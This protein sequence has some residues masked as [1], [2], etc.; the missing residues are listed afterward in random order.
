MPAMG[1]QWMLGVVLQA[2][3]MSLPW[4]A[5]SGHAHEPVVTRHIAT[6]AAPICVR[7]SHDRLIVRRG[8]DVCGA[9]LNRSG[10]PAAAGYLPTACPH[11]DDTYR[12]DAAGLADRCTSL[13]SHGD[14]A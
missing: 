3:G 12:I 11:D 5:D 1:K 4:P 6:T 10:R 14:K 8:R 13:S 2:A 9:S 7:A